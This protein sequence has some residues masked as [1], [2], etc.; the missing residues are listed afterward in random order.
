MA[1]CVGAMLG[2]GEELFGLRALAFGGA[3]ARGPMQGL[4]DVQGVMAASVEFEIPHAMTALRV[5]GRLGG[6]SPARSLPSLP[7]QLFQGSSLPPLLR[8]SAHGSF[9]RSVLGASL[10]TLSLQGFSAASLSLPEV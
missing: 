9:C 6:V 8:A 7:G 3:V 1:P 5:A 10:G 2:L 4:L